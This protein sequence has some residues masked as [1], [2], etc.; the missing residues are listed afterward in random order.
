MALALNLLLNQVY[1]VPGDLVLCTV[2]VGQP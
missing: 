1:Y 2:Q